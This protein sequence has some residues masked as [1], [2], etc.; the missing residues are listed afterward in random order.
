MHLKD[1]ATSLRA[2]ANRRALRRKPLF[3]AMQEPPLPFLILPAFAIGR[4]N[5]RTGAGSE[6]G[7]SDAAPRRPRHD[8]EDPD[9]P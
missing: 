7:S 2:A 3:E 5:F 1:I 4:N 6:E 8:E 9:E